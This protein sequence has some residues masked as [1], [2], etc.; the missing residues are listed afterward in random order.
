[1]RLTALA[2]CLEKQLYMQPYSHL[3]HHITY[4]MY[5]SNHMKPTTLWT[6]GFDWKPKPKC[7]T[8][9]AV[10]SGRSG[11]KTWKCQALK[12]SGGTQHPH[13]VQ[14]M[15]ME[16][17]VPLPKPLVAPLLDNI[18]RAVG[19]GGKVR[20]THVGKSQNHWLL[21]LFES[22]GSWHPACASFGIWHVAISFVGVCHIDHEKKH[23]NIPMD[24]SHKRLE[25]ILHA[26]YHF[27]GFLLPSGLIAV[28]ASP[29]CTTFSR[30]DA[31]WKYHRDH[32]QS[33]KP[34]ISDLAKM[35]DAMVLRLM[36]SL[37]PNIPNSY[38]VEG[39]CTIVNSSKHGRKRAQ[40]HQA[41]EASNTAKRVR[42]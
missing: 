31:R 32:K 16:D 4:C 20:S 37:L 40:S 38:K 42:R 17:K 30:L 33:H 9:K 12:D 15:A 8:E 11:D 7:G 10:Q 41:Q 22:L 3:A 39:K 1:M 34:A 6:N 29:P 5:G 36:T 28:V 27:T 2:G 13:K 21:A 19:Y 23:V 24:L 25:D 35:H 14:N 26:V 18:L